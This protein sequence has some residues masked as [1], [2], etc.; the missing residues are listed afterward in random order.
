MNGVPVDFGG[1]PGPPGTTLML[2]SALIQG[3][4]TNLPFAF[5][6]AAHSSAMDTILKYGTKKQIDIVSIDAVSGFATVAYLESGLSYS[7][8]GKVS[9]SGSIRFLTSG[10]VTN[11]LA[12]VQL[13][14][15]GETY[16]LIPKSAKG[17]EVKPNG[18]FILCDVD[19]PVDALIPTRFISG[20]E[21]ISQGMVHTVWR[22]FVIAE[23][24]DYVYLF[25]S[26]ILSFE[27]NKKLY[28]RFSDVTQY[29]QDTIH[30][31]ESSAVL[32]CMRERFDA[33]C[34]SY[35]YLK[36]NTGRQG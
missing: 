22:V 9:G 25:S 4:G 1:D 35:S 31:L 27:C 30:L 24:Q 7:E 32:G 26:A 23:M 12:K 13:E 10:R 33:A 20:E 3:L 34:H 17:V 15:G 19:V 36:D 28:K 5:L 16:A 29:L 21:I 2:K 8:G 11:I 18:E 14:S 6:F